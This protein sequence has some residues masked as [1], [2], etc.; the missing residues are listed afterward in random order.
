M[1]TRLTF[2]PFVTASQWSTAWQTLFTR[3]KDVNGSTHAA[4]GTLV[5]K[6]TNADAVSLSMAWLAAADKQRWPLWYQYAALAYG[7]SPDRDRLLTSDKQAARPY[8]VEFANDLW[9]STFK[10]ALD[11]DGDKVPGPRL[12]MDGRFDDP[13]FQGEVRAALTEDGAK[14]PL[15]RREPMPT[16]TKK[17]KPKPAKRT[18]FL[19]TVAIYYLAYRVIKNVTGG[20][21]Y[22]G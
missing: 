7:W 14:A 8:P 1:A 18:P 5:P 11:L 17:K 3:A 19:W 15:L 12:D 16:I 22:A 13:V 4:D 20:A 9:L 21:R 10:L 6:L 2:P